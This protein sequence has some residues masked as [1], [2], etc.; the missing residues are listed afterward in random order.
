MDKA[1]TPIVAKIPSRENKRHTLV[2]GL[3][4]GNNPTVVKF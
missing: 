4:F 2:A 1:T 3:T